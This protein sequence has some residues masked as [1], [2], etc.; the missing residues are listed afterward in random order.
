MNHGMGSKA[1]FHE[2]CKKLYRLHIK[3]GMLGT[4]GVRYYLELP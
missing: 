3:T 4:V 1:D 2:K